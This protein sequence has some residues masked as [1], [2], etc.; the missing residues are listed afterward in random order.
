[1]MT[2][3][4]RGFFKVAY[5]ITKMLFY[6][7]VMGPEVMKRTVSDSQKEIVVIRC[8]KRKDR[9][10]IFKIDASKIKKVFCIKGLVVSTRIR[11]FNAIKRI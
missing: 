7:L 6:W 5:V 2:R 1:M 3:V 8:K 10:L 4:L 9:W 11:G